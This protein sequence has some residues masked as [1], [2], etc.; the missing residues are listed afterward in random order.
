MDNPANGRE[1]AAIDWLGVLCAMMADHEQGIKSRLNG[2]K[3]GWRDYRLALTLVSKLLGKA[4]AGLPAHQQRHV[5]NVL[6]THEVTLRPAQIVKTP[7]DMLLIDKAAFRTIINT[8]MAAECAI[9]LKSEDEIRGCKL[10]K[11]LETCIMLEKYPKFG[12]GYTD[13]VTNN[14]LGKYI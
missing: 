7:N 4:V 9:C 8:A 11:A 10:R 6:K 1:M 12:C 14:E 5:R 3:N 13:V 2:V